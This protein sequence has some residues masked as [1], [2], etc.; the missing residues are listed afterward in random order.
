M[1]IL[2]LTKYDNLGAS[3]RLR[4]YQYLSHLAKS[5]IGGDRFSFFSDEYVKQ[6]FSGKVD[7]VTV[8]RAFASRAK[9]LLAAK[10][11]DLIWLE[12]EAFPWV[13]YPLERIF[14][15]RIPYVVDYD[16]AVFHRYDEHRL[17]IVRK[18]LGT[19]IDRIMAGAELVTVGN[20]YL[21]ERAKRAGAKSV[22]IVPTVVDLT[23]YPIRREGAK[24]VFTIGWIGSPSTQKYLEMLRPALAE[25]CRGGRAR[26]VL[27]GAGQVEWPELS[28]ELRP[29]S[30]ETEVD[31]IMKFDVGIMP[32]PDA[33][34]ERG[35]C[36]YK[37]IQYMACSVPVV[38]S[39]VGINRQL[40]VDGSNGFQAATVADWTQALMRLRDDRE[41]AC[42]MGRN[43]R[44][45]VEQN[46][47]LQV[48]L[49][50]L[51][52]LLVKAGGK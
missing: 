45:L 39:P 15:G 19:K 27:V 18:L 41:A 4:T 6:L 35:K 49:P 43:G 40:I 17:G 25:L 10:N 22:E 48:T 23:R 51:V 24:G 46:Y 11:Y 36:G 5:H 12:K 16:D 14:L 8:S 50:R 21:A 30:E 28:I 34:W 26:L 37:L 9:T 38:G 2:F 3:S 44:T 31:E 32:L 13:P 7:V 20:E 1:R 33:P 29:W 47:C 52:N 42:V